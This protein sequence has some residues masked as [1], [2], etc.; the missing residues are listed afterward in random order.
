M[1]TETVHERTLLA[2]LSLAGKAPSVHNSQPW[3]WQLGDNS[4]HLYI[5]ARRWLPATDPHGRDLLLSC[6]TALHH[7][8]VA[9]AALDIDAEVHRMPNPAEPDHLAAIEIRPGTAT[10]SDLLMAAAIDRRR[11]DRRWFSDRPVPAAY[12]RALSTQAGAHGALLVN[13]DDPIDRMRLIAAIETAAAVQ[14]SDSA[15]TVELA[16]WSGQHAA[17]DG[18]PSANVPRPRPEPLDGTVVIPIRDFAEGE[19]DE[20]GTEARDGAIILALGT[21]SDDALSQLRAGEAA[22]AM[23]LAATELGLASSVLSQPLEIAFARRLVR[24]RV[25]GGALCPQLLFRLGWPPA[26]AAEIPATPRRPVN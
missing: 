18:V 15:Y 17:S 4:V 13:T 24:D 3:R 12:L 21:A 26:G 23:L 11:T 22:S 7:L 6:G 8:R 19:L 1:I 14:N 5:D 20:P 9:L 25:L 2:A 16:T 10:E